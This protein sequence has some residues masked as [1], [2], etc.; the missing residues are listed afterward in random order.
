[1]C[2]TCTMKRALGK[3]QHGPR[4]RGATGHRLRMTVPCVGYEGHQGLFR[5]PLLAVAV[6]VLDT[7]VC[8]E[9]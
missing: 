8:S 5:V 6:P 7:D 3:A 1:M 4:A 2:N 9:M